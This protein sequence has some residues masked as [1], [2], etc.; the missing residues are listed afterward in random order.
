MSHRDRNRI[1]CSM[2][3][4][5]CILL[6]FIAFCPAASLKVGV[7]AVNIDPPNGT[8]MAGYYHA[9][10]SEGVLDSLNAKAVVFDDGKTQTA[11]IGC[12]LIGIPGPVAAAARAEIEKATRIAGEHVMIWATHTHTGPSLAKDLADEDFYGN[13]SEPA[14]LYTN[15]LPKKLAQAVMEAKDKLVSA[16]I[17]FARQIESGMSFC[18]RFWMKD[19][20]VGWNPGKGNPNIIRPVGPIDPEVGVVYA[21]AAEDKPVLTF[22]NFAMH[23]DTTGGAKVSADY[24]GALARRL[25]DYKGP[26]MLTLFANGTCGDINHLNVN[27]PYRQQGQQEANRLGTILAGAVFKAYMD[28]RP[29]GDCTLRV[30]RQVVELALPTITDE[31]LS[32]ADAIRKQGDQAKFMDQV[33]AYKTLDVAARKG[34][35]IEAEVQVIAVGTDLAWVAMPGEVFVALGL[36]IKSASPFKQTHVIELANGSIGYIPCR[37][38]YAEGNYEV[39]SSRCAEGSGEMLVSAIVKMLGELYLEAS[40]KV[41]SP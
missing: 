17:F 24:P 34:K 26:E 23:P 18:R 33:F 9:R 36:S 20:T 16:E 10:G 31:Q 41:A 28:M 38:A 1:G 8:P 7:A 12:D 21:L 22:V 32:Q 27:W 11:M 4:S 5:V 35:P 14:K 39:V 15:A 40:P 13:A 19:G 6:S 30:R 37:S 29:T 3:F 2:I 25:A